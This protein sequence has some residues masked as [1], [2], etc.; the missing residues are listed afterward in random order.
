MWRFVLQENIAHLKLLISKLKDPGSL[1]QLRA[2]LQEAED[3]LAELNRLSAHAD[4]EHNASYA[5]LLTSVLRSEVKQRRADFGLMQ[6]LDATRSSLRIAAQLNFNAQYLRHFADVRVGDG[7]VY[8]R[9]LADGEGV[10]VDDIAEADVSQWFVDLA[11]SAGFIALKSLPLKR[12]SG[13]LFGVFSLHYAQP[14]RW[15]DRDRVDDRHVA[16]GLANSVLA[17]RRQI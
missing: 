10:W 13:H 11:L 17:L 12:P 7:S 14:Q 5:S 9:V 4:D 16:N 3:E 6:L 2:E 1:K 15:A 8:G